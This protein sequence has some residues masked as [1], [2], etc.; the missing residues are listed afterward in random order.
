VLG[1]E[2]LIKGRTAQTVVENGRDLLE[3][4]ARVGH[5]NFVTW[6]EGTLPWSVRQS[7]RMMQV[8]ESFKS[9]NLS[10]LQGFQPSA[11]YA[12]AA[13]STPEPA[14]EEAIQKAE[15]GEQISHAEAQELI[16]RHKESEAQLKVAQAELA[17]KPR[18]VEK[19]VLVERVV[20]PSDYEELVREKARLE[21]EKREMQESVESLK[22]AQ[23]ELKKSHS[24]SAKRE[25]EKLLRGKEGRVKWFNDQI[26]SLTKQ[27]QKLDA[28]V[29]AQLAYKEACKVVEQCL[30]KVSF[31][32]QEAFAEYPVP[33]EY[34]PKLEKI[35]K[36]MRQGSEALDRFLTTGRLS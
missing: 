17:K 16:R 15:A 29:G 3:A 18:V 12:L 24:E 33:D 14:R 21:G 26:E 4:K 23:A 8:A 7:Q 35:A 32:L 30:L 6:V 27:Y 31:Q 19:E 22:K 28:A 1:K 20:V 5:G 36:D 34:V 11:L 9:D 10:F 13:S 2:Q 25:L